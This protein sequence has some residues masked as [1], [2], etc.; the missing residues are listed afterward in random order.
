MESKE[1]VKVT[2]EHREPDRVPLYITFN[3]QVAEE[4][5]AYLGMPFQK[6][7]A[8]LSNRISYTDMLVHLGNDCIGI[9]YC[10]P[11]EQPTRQMPD[12]TLQDEWGFVYRIT[13]NPFG[14]Y[15]EIVGRPL[16]YVKSS[17]DLAD[18]N[19]PEVDAP[20]RFDLAREMAAKYGSTHFLIGVVECT[21]FEYCWNLVG[22]EKF[23]VDLC[24]EADYVQPLMYEVMNFNIE[25]G[26]RLI[27]I[28]AEM[29]W[30][31]DDFGTQQGLL[32][33]PSLWRKYFK[34]RMKK[35]FHEYK[36]AN[37]DVYIG[38]HSCGSI[39]A[40]IDDL[41]E[42]GL[43]V[44]NP[45]QPF[46][47]DMEPARLKSKYGDRLSFFGGIDQQHVL[48]KGSPEDVEQELRTRIRELAPGGGYILAP[49]HDIQPDTPLENVLTLFKATRQWGTYPLL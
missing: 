20:G 40:L 34:P 25:V 47:A 11:T 22:L 29:I 37:P 13:R 26:K 46:A 32:I 30:T 14:Q 15:S 1:R 7:D 8:Y 42:I 4:M 48:P 45:I 17:K 33:S 19:L 3:P 28:G 6:A 41:I 18:Y 12:G 10:A 24:E 49:A 16:S 35:V 36:K 43:Q 9:S 23:L 44:L 38:Y 39:A 31:G 21:I 2:L 27:G 5:A